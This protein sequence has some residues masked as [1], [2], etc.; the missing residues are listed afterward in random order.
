MQRHDGRDCNSAPPECYGMRL[1]GTAWRT[2]GRSCA[3]V[4]KMSHLSSADAGLRSVKS[5]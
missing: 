5:A 2:Q 1:R 4:G 3:T